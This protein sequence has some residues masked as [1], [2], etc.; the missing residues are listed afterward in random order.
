MFKLMNM[1]FEL[2]EPCKLVLTNYV[3]VQLVE[4]LVTVF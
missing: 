3:R 4:L 1:L 2:R